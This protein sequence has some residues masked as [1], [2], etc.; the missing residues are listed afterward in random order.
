MTKQIV[1]LVLSLCAVSS[2]RAESLNDVLARMD[3]SAQLFQSMSAGLTQVNHTEIINEN[4][5]QKATVRM[6]KGKGGGIFGRVDFSGP[7]QMIVGIRDRQ[8]Q[9]YYPKSNTVEVYD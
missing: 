6:K 3:K 8:V 9:K 2:I 1:P 5:T 7:N 4:E